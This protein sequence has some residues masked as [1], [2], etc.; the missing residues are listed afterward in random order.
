MSDFEQH[1][2]QE[3]EKRESSGASE[4]ASL[5]N[6]DVLLPKKRYRGLSFFSFSAFFKG[7][8]V[9]SLFLGCLLAWAWFQ[10]EATTQ[11]M[12]DKMASKT[13]IVN[14]D[15]ANIYR[16]GESQPI[17]TMPK[18]DAVKENPDIID[19]NIKED[20]TNSENN[21]E[22]VLTEEPP[23]V[24]DT[25]IAQPIA[26]PPVN[27]GL[28]P[29]PI[30]G[31]YQS[32]VAGLLPVVSKTDNLTPFQ[33]YKRPFKKSSDKPRLSILLFNV[34]L[35][36]KLTRDIIDEFPPEITLSFSPYARD[37]K[38]LT[39][40]ARQRGHEVWLTLP[41][42][43]KNYPL[44]DP[45]PSTLLVNASVEQNQSRLTSLLAS[46]Q[47]YAGFVS[48]KEHVFKREDAD[49]NPSIEEIFKRGLAIVDSNPSLYSFVGDVAAR[50]DY[51]HAKNNFWLDDNLTAIGLNQKIRQIIEYGDSGG[52]VVVMLRPYPASIKALKK[53]LN[54]A[55]A[56]KFQLAPVSAQVSYGE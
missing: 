50:K 53:F 51:P 4:D 2:N 41:L 35:S 7:F 5:D 13:A 14:R 45:G 38:T 33:A 40:A 3:L 18:A 54:S 23:R 34:G 21:S 12:I 26:P 31:L 46:T 32:S 29:A 56:D 1:L 25:I 19:M 43:T 42:E 27:G 49:V 48:Q 15:A 6:D 11:A 20:I 44:N 17:L 36:Q 52:S 37:L 47:G 24:E 28:A 8:V 30:P 16:L 55:A 22:L 10:A 9:C 39:A